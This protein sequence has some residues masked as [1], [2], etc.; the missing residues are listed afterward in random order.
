MTAWLNSA[1]APQL[2]PRLPSR[3]RNRQRTRYDAGKSASRETALFA[4]MAQPPH[5]TRTCPA[6]T[7]TPGYGWRTN[8]VRPDRQRRKPASASRTATQPNP[9]SHRGAAR[10]IMPSM[11]AVHSRRYRGGVG[12]AGLRRLFDAGSWVV[13]TRRRCR[14]WR[15][16]VL[17]QCPRSPPARSGS[18]RPAATADPAFPQVRGPAEV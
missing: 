16:P 11:I 6:H 12:A 10:R 18:C 8:A 15:C 17:R 7:G 3:R 2:T 1:H 9:A 4:L 14:C 5:P 13:K